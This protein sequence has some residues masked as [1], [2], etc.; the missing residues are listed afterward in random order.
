MD[1]Y[2][3]SHFHLMFSFSTG[4]HDPK[5]ALR[6][7]KGDLHILFHKNFNFLQTYT[8]PWSQHIISKDEL[9]HNIDPIVRWSHTLSQ[10]SIATTLYQRHSPYETCW[11]CVIFIA[12]MYWTLI[13]LKQIK[14]E[15][16][17]QICRTPYLLT[18]VYLN[19]VFQH[20][21]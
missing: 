3:F 14:V 6:V 11:Q 20:A 1:K 18:G 12:M 13:T 7:T 15:L 9:L 16:W 17:A 4:V 10:D 21:L 2:V 19:N 8:L 5:W